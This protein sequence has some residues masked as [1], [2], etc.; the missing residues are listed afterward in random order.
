M[1]ISLYQYHRIKREEINTLRQMAHSTEQKARA[2]WE[3]IENGK[4]EEKRLKELHAE[5][6][7]YVD[8]TVRYKLEAA[9][10]NEELSKHTASH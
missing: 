7:W 3:R 8:L 10:I 6:N 9:K 4:F 2:V 5:F 1:E